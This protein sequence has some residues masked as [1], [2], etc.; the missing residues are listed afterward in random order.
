MAEQSFPFE[1]IDTTES[2]FSQWAR[3]FQSTGI[4]GSPTG[5]EVKVSAAGTDLN[6][7]VAAGQAFIRGHYYINTS[8]KTLAVTSAGINTRI[9]IVVVELDPVANTIITKI[10]EGTAVS[11][12]PV[13]PTLTQTDTGTFQLPIAQITIPNSTLA[14]TNEMITDL[15]T[16]M[17]HDIGLWTSTTRP[18]NPTSQQT[19][20]FNTTINQHEYWNG[21]D[22]VEFTPTDSVRVSDYVATGDILV[23]AGASN[24]ERLPI[25]ANNEVLASNGT[26]AYWRAIPS[27]ARSTKFVGKTDKSFA[28]SAGIHSVS[29]VLADGSTDGGSLYL[30]NTE[31][32][33]GT[34][35]DPVLT[36]LP[37]N[38][39]AEYYP[40]L[41]N[42]TMGI[43][44]TANLYAVASNGSNAYVAAT[45]NNG[46]SYSSA[47]YSTDGLTW[48]DINTLKIGA[49]ASFDRVATNGTIFVGGFSN[50]TVR[51]STDGKTWGSPITLGSTAIYGI[52][53]ANSQFV[54]HDSAGVV[55]TST[56]GTTWTSYT[57]TTWTGGH[58]AQYP[59][60]Y[61]TLGWCFASYNPQYIL[62]SNAAG[63]T[64]TYKNVT[65]NTSSNTAGVMFGNGIYVLHGGTGTTPYLWTATDPNGTWT[66]RT[67]GITSNQVYYGAFG[68][69]IFVIMSNNGQTRTSTDGITWTSRTT[70]IVTP[71][72]SLNFN[73]GKFNILANDATGILKN[74]SSTDGI[75]WTSAST[76][77]NW[78][79]PGAIPSSPARTKSA[80]ANGVHI[81]AAET[82]TPYISPDYTYWSKLGTWMDP[83]SN[84]SAASYY[85]T[86]D[87]GKFVL[88]TGYNNQGYTLQYSTDGLYWTIGYS[89]AG[90]TGTMAM[91]T[92]S[93]SETIGYIAC[94]STNST[95]TNAIMISGDGISWTGITPP[96][97]IIFQA[98]AYGAGKYLVGGA[99]LVNS[100]NGLTWGV[101]TS[102]TVSTIR[103][104]LY[105]DSQFVLAAADGTIFVS[106]DTITWTQ[107]PNAPTSIPG[108]PCSFTYVNGAYAYN[109]GL[110]GYVSTDLISWR[111]INRPVTI[112]SGSSV[113]S[114]GGKNVY[115]GSGT[116]NLISKDSATPL[117]MYMQ[118]VNYGNPTELV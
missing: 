18:A 43:G 11:S 56:N 111:K 9:D 59:G 58:Y 76:G 4:K 29:R 113:I 80:Y 98:A 88:A 118:T 36:T 25:G 28:N 94:G 3:N 27:A 74:V 40:P 5:T 110:V 1:N 7:S 23:A 15:R 81:L 12:D 21:T 62:Y 71:N 33:S 96:S 8:S 34:A 66:S 95:Q 26:T 77:I 79:G 85:V 14:I 116:S 107:K 64:W 32:V 67:T 61:G 114:I 44:T 78:N 97:A 73:N 10:V 70:G 86:Y 54:A 13:A 101:I 65:S 106:T 112:G 105:R 37:A 108:I 90:A 60:A 35:A 117:D 30:N 51:T 53:Y 109:N 55:Y 39:R 87:N 52:F 6:I 50:G 49:S 42:Q 75:T 84:A 82:T 100:T 115:Y 45:S 19:L 89:S 63:T 93:Y 57:V 46:T 48:Q 83:V 104:L 99:G 91:Y 16:F 38:S 22:W 68:N 47:A 69:G 72:S 17:S 92:V 41:V 24:P 31:I 2:Q 103:K 20:G 102:P